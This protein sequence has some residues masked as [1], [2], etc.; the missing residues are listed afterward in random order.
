[1]KSPFVNARDYAEAT[2]TLAPEPDL[3]LCEVPGGWAVDGLVVVYGREERQ[4]IVG[5]EWDPYGTA[6]EAM[7]A[8]VERVGV[9]PRGLWGDGPSAEAEG[10]DQ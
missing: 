10:L 8:C 4:F 7:D 9:Y 5:S 2:G 1:M 6:K 3:R